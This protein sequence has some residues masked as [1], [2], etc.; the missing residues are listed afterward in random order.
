MLTEER[1][2]RIMDLLHKNSFVSIQDLMK[3]FQVSRSSHY[4]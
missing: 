4:A 3:R 1:M 2:V